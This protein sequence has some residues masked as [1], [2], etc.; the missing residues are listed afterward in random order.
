MVDERAR[1]QLELIGEFVA[2]AAGA[3]VECWLR[4]GWGLDFLLGTVTRPHEDIDLFVW[5]D[6]APRLLA[7]LAQHGYQEVGGPPPEQQRNLVKAGEEFHMTL[8][9]RNQRGVVTAGGRWADSPWPAGML[10]GPTGRIGDVR[11]RVISAEAQLWAKE[12]VPKALGRAQ[13]EHD[14]VD[15]A[16]LR[17]A[18]VRA[19]VSPSIRPFEAEDAGRVD[20]LLHVLAPTRVETA[21]SLVWRQSSEPERSRRCSWVAV[22]S[23]DVVGFA[24]AHL[25]WFGGEAGKGR[26]WV[27]VREDRRR[28]GI[29]SVLWETAV[30]HLRGAR[31]HTVEVDDHP[32]GLAFVER[33]GFTQYDAEVISRLDPRECRLEAKPHEGYRVVSLRDVL[34]REHDLY[35]FYGAA[36][37]MSPADPENRVTLEEWRRFILGNPLLNEDASVVVECGERIVSLAWLLVDHGRKRAENEWTATMPELRGRGLARL[38]KL[39]T[40]RWAAENGIAEIVTG[41]D[42]D[43][44]PM[45]E[46]NR[47]LG[48]VELFLRR[49]LERPAPEGDRDAEGV[50]RSVREGG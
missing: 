23:E 31:K 6:D 46:L 43:N 49:D 9:D 10:E 27:G 37:A 15:V 35:E 29:G 25:Q 5:A 40:I 4:G 24:T 33:R 8:L 30:A 18:L 19:G 17:E 7:V 21:E 47:R 13:R 11:S 2:L 16:L 48:Y 41:I 36:G 50:R 26:I 20:R 34:D 1:R 3:G 32:A 14:P 28:R 12:E 38:A 39:A 45:R 44:L 42:P 22:E